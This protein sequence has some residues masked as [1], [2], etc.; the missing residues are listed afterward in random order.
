[1][2][3][4]PS[5]HSRVVPL[6]LL[7]LTACAS[8]G[9][10]FT[11][12]VGDTYFDRPPFYAGAGAATGQR[13]GALPI[14]YQ[15]GATGSQMSDPEGGAGTPVAALLDEMNRYLDSLGVATRLDAALP[16]TPPDVTFGCRTTGTLL[17]DC[18]DP[19]SLEGSRGVFDKSPGRLRLAVG[20]PSREWS[21]AA[22]SA[23]ARAGVAGTL[24]MTLELGQYYVRQK[25]FRGSKEVELGTGYSASFPWLTSLDTPVQVVQLTGALMDR[26]G[27]ALRIGAEGLLAKR[28]SFGVSVLKAQSLVTDEDL[29]ALRTARRSDLPGQPLV[30]QVALRNLVA[31]LAG[32]TELATR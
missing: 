31:G 17:D 6:A 30:W 25:N 12:G 3:L 23:M 13:V 28:T 26:G 2:Y 10:T 8:T 4:S 14:T 21:A 27:K 15:R 11:S 22:D 1:M 24:V 18:V 9:A 7:G 5:M 32:R 19:D 29:A 20:R 16:G